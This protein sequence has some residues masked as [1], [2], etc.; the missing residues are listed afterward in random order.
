MTLI[1][2]WCQMINSCLAF[3]LKVQ[4]HCFLSGPSNTRIQE[5]SAKEHS[6][7]PGSYGDLFWTE[8]AQLR[9]VQEGSKDSCAP[10]Q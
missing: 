3:L 4:H 9:N 2:F 7:F 10:G 5:S 6:P 8:I 1:V